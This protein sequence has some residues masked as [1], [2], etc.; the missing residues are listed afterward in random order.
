MEGLERAFRLLCVCVTN[1][2]IQCLL[3]ISNEN[4]AAFE[5]A[6]QV[7]VSD[8]GFVWN[9]LMKSIK[10]AEFMLAMKGFV[11]EVANC[12]G[13]QSET[14]VHG[15]TT[16]RVERDTQGANLTESFIYT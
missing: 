4:R 13:R 7:F 12:T 10:M 15:E 9:K 11:R 8:K 5:K 3:L 16:L 6:C 1:L 2:Q 14:L